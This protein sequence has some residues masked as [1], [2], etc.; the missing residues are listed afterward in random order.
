MI[1]ETR[2]SN[3]LGIDWTHP[4]FRSSAMLAD[5]SVYGMVESRRGD[6][7]EDDRLILNGVPYHEEVAV[8]HG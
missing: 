2:K 4:D 7:R 8:G 6:F 5:G 1:R 3:A